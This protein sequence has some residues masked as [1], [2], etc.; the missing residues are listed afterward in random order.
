MIADGAGGA[1]LAWT[2][3]RRGERN[4]DIYAQ[5]VDGSGQSLWPKDGLLV[6]GAPDVQKSPTLTKDIEGGV[7]IAWTDKGGGSYDIYA[8]RVSKEGKPLW[9]TDGIPIS[10]S[11]RTQQ[12]PIIKNQLVVWEDYRYG[13]WDIYA[14]SLSLQGKLLWGED[15]VP[16]VSQPLT[17]YA[18]QVAIMGKYGNIIAWEDYRNGKQYEVYMQLLNENGQTLWAQNGFNV[19]STDGARAPKLLAFPGRNSFLVVWDDYTGGGKAISGQFY[20][21]TD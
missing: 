3:Y 14:N 13:N 2:D 17:Q 10:Q 19:R 1:F 8:Q 9:L 12:D 20:N 5:R 15:G 6:C 21:I 11:P 18:P 7:I 4:P 16:V